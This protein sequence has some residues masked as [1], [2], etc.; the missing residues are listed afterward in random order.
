M[1]IYTRILITALLLCLAVLNHHGLLDEAGYNYTQTGIKRTLVTFA[2]ARGLNGIISVVQGTEVAVEPVGVGLTFTPGQILDPVNDLIERFSWVV[3]ASGTSLGIQEIMLHM[4]V[5]FWFE[6]VVTSL[7]VMTLIL[8]WL[9]VPASRAA[10]ILFRLTLITIVLRFIVPAAALT[11]EVVYR[12]FLEP[13]Y[14]ESSEQLQ[15]TSLRLDDMNRNTQGSA[16]PGNDDEGIIASARRLYRSAADSV[17]MEARIEAFRR[18][19]ENISEHTIN[20]IVIFVIQNLLIPLFYL[21]LLM[22]TAKWCIHRK[23][24]GTPDSR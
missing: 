2:V 13:R 4:S 24:Q 18:A 10:S 3:L 9:Q 1:N 5:G 22:Q 23:L 17:N 12:N 8:V 7:I 6:I 19:A 21:W 16:D 20:L 15:Q 11:N 14:I